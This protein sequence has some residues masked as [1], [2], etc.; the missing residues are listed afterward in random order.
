MTTKFSQIPFKLKTPVQCKPG[1]PSF[2]SCDPPLPL[3]RLQCF[4][5][6][7]DLI[8]VEPFDL[9]AVFELLYKHTD[10]SYEATSAQTGQRLI[11]RV[12]PTAAPDEFDFFIQAW[13][14]IGLIHDHSW[15]AVTCATGL[16]FESPF[17]W[18]HDPHPA[19]PVTLLVTT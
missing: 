15:N 7:R 9:S 16:Y 19:A 13:G 6:W 10:K 12:S 17:L 2:S 4:A 1:P 18:T 5:S 11:V 14:T 8:A 3:P